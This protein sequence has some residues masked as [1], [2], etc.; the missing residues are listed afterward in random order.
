M[1]KNSILNKLRCEASNSIIDQQLAA[2]IIKGNKMISKPCCNVPRSI[3]HGYFCGSLHAEAHAILSYYGK[4]LSFDKKNGWCFLS[5][6][7]FKDSKD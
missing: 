6:K 4:S 2:A 7:K 3:C 1:S 5:R